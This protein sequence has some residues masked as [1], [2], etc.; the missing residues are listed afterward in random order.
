MGREGG[1][2]RVSWCWRGSMSL[3]PAAT[4][5]RWGPWVAEPCQRVS[6]A[7]TH[8]HVP[9]P[10][11]AQSLHGWDGGTPMAQPAG[12]MLQ[13]VQRHRGYP[14][15]QTGHSRKGPHSMS[16]TSHKGLSPLARVAPTSS[17]GTVRLLLRAPVPH[18]GMTK[19][20]KAQAEGRRWLR[21]LEGDGPSAMSPP[22]A[23]PGYLHVE[24]ERPSSVQAEGA[25]VRVAG[26]RK[27]ILRP[28]A[29]AHQIS[30]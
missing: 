8:P 18:P 1:S 5:V 14:Q 22:C 9:T 17:P 7:A 30:P 25:A 6:Q 19:A 2:E 13:L 28:P 4:P 15:P 20:K 10:W 29:R 12:G 27:A 26:H 21:G 3:A 24:R 16:P 23:S 11:A